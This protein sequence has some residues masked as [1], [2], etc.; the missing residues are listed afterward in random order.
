MDMPHVLSA[1]RCGFLKKFHRFFTLLLC[2]ALLLCGSACRS[3]EGAAYS[4]L[5]TVGEKHY[6]SVFRL[7]D[8]AAGQVDAAMRELAANGE[9]SRICQQWLGRDLISLKGES[10]AVAALEE[11][12][13]A[14]VLIVGVE[15]DFDRLSSPDE[16]GVYAG[17]SVDLANAIGQQL[18]WEIRIQPI[19]AGDMAT[20]LSSGNIDCALGFGIECINRQKFTT[21]LCYMK[22]DIVVAVPGDSDIRRPKQLKGLKIGA[23]K[24]AS[25]LAALEN[26]SDAGKYAESVTPY[27]SPLRCLNALD[28]GWCAAIAMDQVMLGQYS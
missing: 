19:N 17:M 15:N 11:A 25:I 12:P 10:G 5:E 24:D 18:G 21:G 16:S 4:I 28:N 1:G 26:D 23:V 22:S 2:A 7:G 8:K 3:D 14:R 13:R 6:G 20:Q 27:L 9:L